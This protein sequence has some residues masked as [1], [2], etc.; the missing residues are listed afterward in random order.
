MLFSSQI[1]LFFFLPL[2]LAFYGFTRRRFRNIALLIISATFYCYGESEHVYILC[3]SIM[4]NYFGGLLVGFN[5]S[6][7]NIKFRQF[8][9]TL[10]ICLNLGILG[11]FKYFNFVYRNLDTGLK[12]IGFDEL[13]NYIHNPGAIVLPLGISFFTFQAMSYVIDV[14][15]GDVKANKNPLNIMAYIIMFPQL[16]AGPIVRYIEIEHDLKHRNYSWESFSEGVYRFSIGL[17]K[18]LIIADTLG[19]MCDRIF[20]LNDEFISFPIAWYAIICYSFQI[21]FDF[22]GYS[23]MAIGLGRFFGFKFP[24]NFNYPYVAQSVQD[25]WRRWHMT[26]SRWFRDYLYIPL[27]G[28]RK[29]AWR[30][31]FNLIVVFGLCGFWHG[32]NWVFLAWGLWHGFFLVLERTRF[33]I[34]QNRWPRVLRHIYTI[35][36]VA[37]GWVWFRSG[38]MSQAFVFIKTMIGLNGYGS[39]GYSIHE[40]SSVFHIIILALA[41]VCSLPVIPILQKKLTNDSVILDS[42][43]LLLAVICLA[44]T[45]IHLMVGSYTPFLYFRF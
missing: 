39:K 45:V 40:F 22:S 24:E 28:N 10:T 17:T 35:L 38:Y 3:A 11:Y 33:G 26:L 2:C 31:Y 37:F 15:R 21:Y 20:A 18:K 9:L 8:I 29:G 36:V 42:L 19:Q 43:K 25:F 44:L 13:C 32:A 5:A 23:D 16:I 1:F 12:K 34:W 7:D 41:V 27:G 6:T 4:I 30:T 14:Y